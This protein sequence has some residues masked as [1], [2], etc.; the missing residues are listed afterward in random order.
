MGLRH[1]RTK[2]YIGFGAF[3]KRHNMQSFPAFKRASCQD[4]ADGP[5]ISHCRAR[6][7]GN[8]QGF[9]IHINRDLRY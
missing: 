5:M 3:I 9:K 2:L 6:V 8:M 7:K 4:A 1:I